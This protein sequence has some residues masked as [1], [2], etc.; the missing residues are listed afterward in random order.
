[1]T[2]Y[3]CQDGRGK[4]KERPEAWEANKNQAPNHVERPTGSRPGPH[5]MTG[6]MA[7]LFS[8]RSPGLPV[9]TPMV[10]ES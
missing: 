7:C 10:R 6:H 8:A 3:Q 5:E 4:E 2:N 9:Q 1:M